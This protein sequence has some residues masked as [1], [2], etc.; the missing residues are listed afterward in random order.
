MSE[1]KEICYQQWV[2]MFN[3]KS[4][5]CFK[6]S[7]ELAKLQEENARLRTQNTCRKRSIKTKC[8]CK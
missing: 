2:D 4:K 7:L 1:C 6:L 5:E 3:Q 8:I